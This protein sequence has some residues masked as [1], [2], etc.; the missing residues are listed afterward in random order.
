MLTHE[1]LADICPSPLQPAIRLGREARLTSQRE[2][3]EGSRRPQA[4]QTGY[5][6][7]PLGYLVRFSKL[8]AM[9][10][11]PVGFFP[12]RD[13]MNSDLATW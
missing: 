10:R 3:V 11:V 5:S 6:S 2:R 13:R 4:E 1:Y 12:N 9:F 7:L 8:Q